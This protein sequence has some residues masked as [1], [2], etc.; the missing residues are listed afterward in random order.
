[1]KRSDEYWAQR[2]K[3]EGYRS[4][5]SYKL[6]QLD[7]KY[8][9]ITK[10]SLIFDLG[11]A[12]GGW[13]QV[14]AEKINVSAKCIAIDILNMQRVDKVEFHQIDLFSNEFKDMMNKNLYYMERI[15]NLL[16]TNN[17]ELSIA[18][19]P[20]PSQILWD[21][22]DNNHVRLWKNF[23]NDKCY[24]FLNNYEN[25]FKE[26]DRTDRWS[27]IERYY[28]L[29]DVH[30]NSEGNRLIAENFIENFYSKSQSSK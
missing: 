9:L 22:A 17:I 1:M 3:K 13:S 25:F 18:V 26:V 30:Y 29:N 27:V 14:I 24:M 16:K 21:K 19:Y 7:E 5:A 10:S 8:N 28:I 23:C 20:W 12:P 4:R 6:L 11:C 15:Y 2:A